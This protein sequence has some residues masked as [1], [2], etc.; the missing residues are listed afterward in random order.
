MTA[1]GFGEVIAALRHVSGVDFSQYRDTTIKR[2][3]AR[4]MLLRGFKSPRDYAQFLGRDAAEADALYRD[5]LINVTS[6]FREP[7]MFEELKQL[8]FPEIVK[9]KDQSQPIRVWVP[10]CSTGQ[11][12]YSLAIALLEFLSASKQP[13]EIQ[14]F[15]TDL[16]D[17]AALDQARNG[18]YPANI[19]SEVS[20]ERL[21]QFFTKTDRGYRIQK[22]VR[23]LC[24][25][26]RQNITVDPP[27]SRVDLISCRNVLIYMSTPLQERLLPVFHFALNRGGFLV[28]GVAET[29]GPSAD[30]FEPASRTHKIY[31]RRDSLRRAQLTLLLEQWLPEAGTR[32]GDPP[33]QPSDVQRE[34]DRLTLSRYAPPAVLVNGQFEVVQ[35]RGRTA[36]FLEAPAGQ[37]TTN[38]LR[39]AREG[40]FTE[41][42]SALEAAKGTQAPAIR[43]HLRISDGGHDL[44]FTLRV[45]PVRAPRSDLSLLVVFESEEREPMLPA[46]ELPASTAPGE[47]DVD[48][49]RGELDASKEY[50]QSMLDAQD[51]ANQELRAAHEEVLS[52]NEELQSTNE[53]LETTKEELQSANEELSTVNEQ[54][55]NRNRELDVLADELSNFISSADV[56][57]VTVGRDL[58]IHRLTPAAHRA[59]NVVASD[60]G[61]SIAHIKFVLDVDDI[62]RIV[63]SVIASMQPRDSEHQD[64]DGRWW[65]LRVRPYLTSDQR[66]DGAT[67]VAVDIDAI[68]RHHDIVAARDYALAVVQTVREPLV[69]LGSDCRVGLANQA[70]YDLVGETREQTEGKFIWETSRGL[71]NDAAL[72]RTL[73]SACEG[74]ELVS[75]EI[76][77]VVPPRGLRTLVLN[78]R[79]ITRIGQ[80]GLLLLSVDD[81]TDARLAERL[82]VDAETLRMV[83]RRKDEFLGILA[84]ELRNPLAPMRFALELMRQGGPS[85]VA[86]ARQVL[87]RQVGHM[88]RIVD[89]LL[90]VSRIAHGK[91]ELRKEPLQLVSIVNSAVELSRPAVDAARHTLTV[92]LPDE[93]VTINGDQ[94][95]LTQVFV[96]LLNNAVKFTPPGGHI[97]LIAE[98]T[99]DIPERPDQVR[100]RVRDTGI[101][102]TPEQQRTVFDMFTQGDRSLERTR[103]GLGVGLTLVRNLVALHGGSIEVRSDGV[104]RGSEFVVTLPIELDAE[105]IPPPAGPSAARHSRPLRILV[106]DDSDDGREM[107]AFLLTREGHTVVT[108]EDGERA[109]EKLA[110]FDADVA[111]L[112]I[113]MPGL[114]GYDV[115]KAL[116]AARPESP[117][118][119]IA[120]SGLGQANDKSRAIEAG[121]DQHFTKPVEV[122]SLLNLLA[123]KFQ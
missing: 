52:S 13:Q 54:L 14:V 65:M 59:F 78:A 17:P 114:N 123:Q 93:T 115:V 79:A 32:R 117:P 11:E 111:V 62:G 57:M 98:R 120:L 89:D 38:I 34:A 72:R 7:A 5:V 68:K 116:R 76:Q 77:R 118:F 110:G 95:R 39:M 24:V 85:E 102:I 49:L 81:V 83:D 109:I 121:F 31:R 25:F 36:P 30:L 29:A 66:I 58:V 90:D 8:V 70:F 86:K 2:R 113:G 28:L 104:G 42:R 99:G 63:A 91:V 94:V 100:I 33:A 43:E 15:A 88:V 71:W 18:V 44:T 112:D 20:P 101:G 96:N 22:S 61:R 122:G 48:W 75:H 37:P 35:F 19:E 23:D 119:L 105:A 51:A 87:D 74:Q 60:I 47:R 106:A 6:F 46:P 10:G 50:L 9:N 53:E 56:P 3:T 67:L 107:L 1:T 73:Q 41:L 97:W 40:L 27:F 80:P 108:A 16:G 21:A 12:A 69:V 84:H 26:A 92:S 45:L 4:R 64:R 55:Q 103:G 82:R